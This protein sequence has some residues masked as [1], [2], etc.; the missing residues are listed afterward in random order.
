MKEFAI[1]SVII[2]GLAGSIFYF[3]VY[4]PISRAKQRFNQSGYT[5]GQKVRLKLDGRPGM[6]VGWRLKGV[7]VRIGGPV[8]RTRTSL[9]GPDETIERTSLSILKLD[10]YEIEPWKEDVE[11]AAP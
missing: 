4:Q 7:R 9:I 1:T 11:H 6:I 8:D 10:Y 3:G 2:L 5:L